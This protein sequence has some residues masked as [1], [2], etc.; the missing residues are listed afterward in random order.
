MEQVIKNDKVCVVKIH[1]I[2]RYNSLLKDTVKTMQNMPYEQ[3]K[4]IL[5]TEI[6]SIAT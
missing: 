6:K 2:A 4:V 5:S 1:L 3:Y